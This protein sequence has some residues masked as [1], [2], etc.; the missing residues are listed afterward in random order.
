MIRVNFGGGRRMG[1]IGCLFSSVIGFLALGAALVI[2][3]VV[4]SMLRS[5]DVVT[6]AVALAE[7]DGRATAALGTPIEVGW[8][9]SGSMSTDGAGNG[10]AS[11]NVPVSG[12]QGSGQLRLVAHKSGGEWEF[13]S[14]TIAIKATGETIDLLGS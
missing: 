9:V 8:L 6:E 2:V 3:V 7:A 5:S 14:L 1:P 13:S 12:P 4:F 11:L 10:Y